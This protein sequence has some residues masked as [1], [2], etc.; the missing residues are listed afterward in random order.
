MVA[1]YD[2]AVPGGVNAHIHALCRALDR[3]GH[4]LIIYG[5]SSNDAR[6]GRNQV[7]V[8]GSIPLNIG[9][10]VSGLGLNVFRDGGVRRLLAREKFD[11]VHIHEP[12]APVIPILFLRNAPCPVVGTFHVHRE[13][14]HKIYAATAWLLRSWIGLIDHRIAVSGAARGTVSRYFPGRYEVIPNGVDVARFRNGTRGAAIP[15]KNGSPEILFVGRI[16]GRKGLPHLIEAMPAVLRSVP[17]SRLVVV[18]DG[19]GRLEAQSIA[20]GLGVDVH[21]AGPVS[22]AD[23]VAYFQRADVVCSPA[24]GGES[25]G[26]VLLEAMA[27]GRAVVASDIEG[28]AD[29]IRPDDSGILVPPGDPVAL[30]GALTGVLTDDALRSS[31]ERR[32][33][34]AA[35]AYDWSLVAARIEAIYLDLV[36]RPRR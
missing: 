5:P 6:L 4:E 36:T 1:P 15:A 35:E 2:M 19:P 31:L 21:F 8:G 14:G 18:G 27:A 33:R 9:G 10:T 7:P 16:E 22:D 34:K 32:A 20:D 11:V 26:I 17:S 29:L 23:L 3:R 25:F 13:G 12:L 30:A 28:Y 24:T